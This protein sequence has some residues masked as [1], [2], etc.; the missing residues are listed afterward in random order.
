MTS[1]ATPNQLIGGPLGRRASASEPGWPANATVYAVATLTW[2]VLMLRQLPC[3]ANPGSPY[4]ALCYSDITALWGARGISEAA[5]PYVEAELEYPVLTG[6]F[7]WVTRL[8]S[9]LFPTPDPRLTFFGLSAL[10]LFACFLGLVAVHARLDRGTVLLIAGSPLVAMG[11][12]INWD[13]LP[14]LLTSAAVLAWARRRPVWAGVLIGLGISA[15]L[16]QGFLLIGLVALCLRSARYRDLGVLLGGTAAGF[17]AVNLPVLLASPH[18]WV[19]LW[20]FH[21]G[22]GADL[23]SIW[24]VFTTAGYELPWAATASRL[25]ML[26]GFAAIG[27]IGLLAP[28]RPRVTQLAFLAITWFC[29]TNVVYSPQ[30]M[31]WILPLLVLAR[32]KVADWLMFT[33]AEAFY[34]WAIWLYLDGELYAGDSLPRVYWVAVLVRVGV[35][36]WLSAVVLRDIVLPWRDPARTPLVDDPAGGVL[37]GTPDAA[38]VPRRREAPWRAV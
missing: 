7:I 36:L 8:A 10:A 13:M 25:L 28:H 32:P 23:G 30:Y 6:L 26:A 22:R 38:W 20:G 5:I 33:V 12:L 4:R 21:A 27:L 14:V 34:W 3:V 18:G 37:E 19:H 2:L 15:K 9:G 31:L 17:A 24:Y 16:Y 1:P 29:L 11:G 35:Q